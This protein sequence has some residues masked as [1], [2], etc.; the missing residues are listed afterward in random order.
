MRVMGYRVGLGLWLALAT[1]VA[2]TRAEA[3]VSNDSTVAVP[4]MGHCLVCAVKHGEADDEPVRARRTHEGRIYGFCSENCA[5]AFAQDP[6][7]YLPRTFPYAAPAFALTT[8]QG[9][10][11][12]LASLAGR[13]VLVDFWATWCAP[14]RKSMPGLQALHERYAAKGL[15]VLG[16]SI[17]EKADAKVRR[18]VREQRFT[19][20]IAIDVARTPTWEAYRVK[21]VPAA[22]LIDREGRVVAQWTGRAP[23]EEEL[24]V[25]IERALMLEGSRSPRAD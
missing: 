15:V 24:T 16:V 18:F 23:Q 3:A 4:A 13:V 2:E 5:Q 25:A 1:F 11:V 20:P 19:Y 21:S 17:D 10:A 8:L 14:C 7:A 9:E 12:S 6:Q 22:F